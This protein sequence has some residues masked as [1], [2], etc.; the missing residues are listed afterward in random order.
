MPASLRAFCVGA[1]ICWLPQRPSDS[2]PGAF[3]GGHGCSG[4]PGPFGSDLTVMK[5]HGYGQ[6][7]NNFLK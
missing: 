5:G 1:R 3:V 2:D 4:T 7:F 6:M